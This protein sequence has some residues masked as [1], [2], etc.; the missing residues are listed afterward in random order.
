MKSLRATLLG[1]LLA[2]TLLVGSS[3]SANASTT[4][5]LRGEWSYEVTC[6]C[7]FPVFGG[8]SLSGTMIISSMSLS[9]G[10]FSGSGQLEGEVPASVSGTATGSALSLVYLTGPAGEESLTTT[11]TVEAGGTEIK[12]AGTWNNPGAPTGTFV[13]KKT[14]SWAEVEKEMI[15]K[16]AREKGEREGKLKGEKEGK[17]AG[18]RTGKAEGEK[19]G[20]EVGEKTGK[21][22]G[23]KT[24]K[25][26]AEQEVKL[27]TEQEATERQ[28]KEAQ[29]KSEKEAKEKTEREAAEKADTQA[30]EKVERE[31][32]EKVAK[33]AG[34]RKS[35]EE[36]KHKKKRRKKRKHKPHAK[37]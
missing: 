12:T 20:K 15:E 25:E 11:G 29:A 27:K 9:S 36:K 33:E 4:E 35:A 14:R 32:R 2:C 30:R 5:E 31:A 1:T 23:E 7:E 21:E 19:T 6:S 34:E 24:G 18:E 22:A 17:E 8:H 28:A 26:K 13:A 16:E 37:R 10:V 3:A